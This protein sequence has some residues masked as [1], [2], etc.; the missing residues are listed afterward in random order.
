MRAMARHDAL[1]AEK[2][3]ILQLETLYDLAIALHAQRPEQEL[4][5]ELL[6]RVC[7]VLDPGAAVAVTRDAY[8]GRARGRQCRLGGRAAGRRRA[9]RGADLARAA[10]RGAHAVRAGGELAGRPYDQLL[11]AP[12]SYRGVFLGYVAVLDKEVRGGRGPLL[13]LRRPP[14]PRLGDRAGRRRPR[15]RPPGRAPGDPARA[16]GGREQ[17]AQGAARPGGRRTPDR[18]PGAADA[19]RA[20]RHRAGGAARRQ[21]PAARGE[22]HRQGAGGQAPA[23]SLGARGGADRRQLRGAPR[24]AA[25]ERAVRHRGRG[26]DRRPGAAGQVRARR[27]RHALPRRD[28]R[29]ADLAAGA[30]A[31][32]APGARGRRASAAGGRSRWTCGWWPRHTRISRR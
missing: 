27:P 24:V 2:R 31:A 16:A 18:G 28:R 17:G 15:R 7:A 30:P 5:D 14:F 21:R 1:I 22:R 23:P 8:G 13:H 3:R 20:R 9:P 29:H 12:L 25:R 32:G 19:P 6:Q 10:D 26:G 4:V 11:A